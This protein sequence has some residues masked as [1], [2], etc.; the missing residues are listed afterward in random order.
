MKK[1]GFIGLGYLGS[2]IAR[3]LISEGI[4]LL[5]WNRTGQKA[6]DLG[7]E[8]A[9][10]PVDL[11]RQADVIF[12]SLF[13]S[14]AVRDVL[15]GK[16]GLFETDLL[17]KLIIDTT[18]N[19]FDDVL[20]FHKECAEAGCRYLEAPV[21]GSVVP[22]SQGNLVVLASGQLEAFD[23]ARPFLEK[24]GKNIFFLGEASLATKMKLVNNL[25][26]GN[27]MAVIAEA[28]VMG[29]RTGLGKDAVLEI[30]SAGAGNSGVMNAKRQKILD[31]N[32]ETHFSAALIYKDLHYMQDLAKTFNTPLFTAAVTKE[33]FGMTF[34][35]NQQVMDMSVIYDVLKTR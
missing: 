17:G 25:V 33:L 3:R 19:H 13:D 9:G 23:A 34:K 8:I 7:V 10:S 24:I 21:L 29:E 12:L 2:A 22:A 14:A 26:L 32:F 20:F 18:T 11:A 31:N 1:V 5:V 35:N 27:F 4:E 28:V 16:N 6:I 15:S 30:L